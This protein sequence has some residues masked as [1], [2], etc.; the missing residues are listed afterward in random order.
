MKTRKVFVELADDGE[1]YLAVQ[2][3]PSTLDGAWDEMPM[4]RLAV[5]REVCT[6]TTFYEVG[7]VEELMKGEV[8]VERLVERSVPSRLEGEARALIVVADQIKL[9]PLMRDM[10]ERVRKAL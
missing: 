5:S 10:V 1:L 6:G 3:K 4:M 2:A 9:P 8:L 7:T